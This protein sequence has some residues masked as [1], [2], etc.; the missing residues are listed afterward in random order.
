MSK[1]CILLLIL[2][3]F[4]NDVCGESLNKL[5]LDPSAISVK[6][7]GHPRILLLKGE[8]KQI[9]KAI[10]QNGNLKKV[11]E[12]IISASNEF[13]ERP[14]L[15]REMEGKRLLG[16]SRECLK[17]VFYLSYAYR[18]TKNEMYAKRAEKEMMAVSEFSDW[19]PSHFLDVAEMTMGIAIGYDWLYDF[20]PEKSKIVIKR[21]IL[22]KGINPSFAEKGNWWING[23]NNWNQVCHAGISYGAL[24]LYEDDKSRGE[25]ILQRAVTNL[26]AVMKGYNPD[27]AYPEG[28]NYW[29]YGTMF[30]VLFIDAYEKFKRVDYSLDGL[31]G[32]L[33]TPYYMLHMEGTSNSSFNYSD[34]GNG[35]DIQPAMYWFAKKTK[36]PSLI[37]NEAKF[38]ERNSFSKLT[39][40]RTLPALLIWSKDFS[41]SKTTVPTNLTW[42]GLGPNPVY[43]MRTSWTDP[44]AIYMGLK[45][46]SPSISHGHMDIGSFVLDAE[47][48]RWASDFGMQSYITL[49][50]KGVDL[51]NMRQ[52]S[53]RWTVFRYNNFA[54][55]TLTINNQL[56]LV[57]SN[58]ELVLTH[59]IKI[60]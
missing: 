25:A 30:N 32:F 60:L 52:N 43:L 28:Y 38:I 34:A 12:A 55:N 11:H 27:G 21:A 40:E 51:W 48:E 5:S 31:N 29:G 56:Q 53:Q 47:G 8:E 49:E 36:D 37:W 23:T 41:A 20:L 16:I 58:A 35:V 39:T 3:L 15:K 17:R 6:E 4:I 46:G 42:Y 50:S 57:N 44:N 14:L 59:L 24:A 9:E 54:H 10:A 18:M 33:K 45:C 22:E 26:P 1:Y 19:N 2:H 13:L 7:T